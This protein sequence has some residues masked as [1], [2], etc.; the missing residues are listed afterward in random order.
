MAVF[1]EGTTYR[2]CSACP[3]RF[4]MFVRWRQIN[5]TTPECHSALHTWMRKVMEESSIVATGEQ[6]GLFAVSFAA[7][8]V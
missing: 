6:D 5:L 2:S 3:A 1:D 8:I 7:W 4:Q